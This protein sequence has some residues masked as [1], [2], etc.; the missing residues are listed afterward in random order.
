MARA[1]EGRRRRVAMALA[2][3]ALVAG[4]GGQPQ[5]HNEAE[6][7]FT[8]W[9]NH[10]ER[11]SDNGRARTPDFEEPSNVMERASPGNAR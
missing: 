9:A 7:E 8:A 11:E 10:V 6:N 5:R 3:F 2:A 4:C 1:K